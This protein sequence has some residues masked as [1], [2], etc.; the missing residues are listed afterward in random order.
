MTKTKKA[1]KKMTG[2]NNEKV[3]IQQYAQSQ[4][5]RLQNT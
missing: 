4:A 5:K 1:A 3:K 2:G